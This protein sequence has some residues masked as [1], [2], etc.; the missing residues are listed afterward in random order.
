MHPIGR[1][2]GKTQ[3]ATDITDSS[4]GLRDWLMGLPRRLKV[5]H[6][7]RLEAKMW[8]RD[9]RERAAI[10]ACFNERYVV[11]TLYDPES[12][13]IL[14][15][16][17]GWFGREVTDG[18]RWMC[19]NCNKIHAPVRMDSFTGPVYPPCCHFDGRWRYDTLGKKGQLK[20]PIGWS[21]PNGLYIRFLRTNI[22]SKPP[23]K[24]TPPSFD[25]TM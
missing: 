11:A 5:W 4:R 17:T 15:G 25:R 8:K 24:G 2:T 19:P 23:Y 3:M 16:G 10:A 20:R 12:K 1:Q 21:G 7:R 14:P 22:H 18:Y 13:M 6:L 9:I